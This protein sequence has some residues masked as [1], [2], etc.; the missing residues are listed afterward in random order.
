MAQTHDVSLAKKTVFAALV[1][2][3]LVA[4][5]EL[6]AYAGG[7][8]VAGRKFSLPR[9]QRQRDA[10][11]AS[12]GRVTLRANTRWTQDE[13]LHPYLGFAPPPGGITPVGVGSALAA[14]PPTRA[15][16][17]VIVAFVGGSFAQVFYDDGAPHL[18]ARLGELPMYRGKTLVPVS[19]GFA[20]YKQPQQLLSIVYL[21]AVGAEF[22][23]IVNI[24]GFNDLAIHPTENAA[25]GVFPPYPRRWHQRM[26]GVLPGGALRLMLRRVQLEQRRAALAEAFSTWPWRHLNAANFLYAVV[27]RDLD[28]RVTETD[29]ALL[30]EDEKGGASAVATGP[31]MSF[32]SDAEMVT[33][34]VD[35]WQRGSRLLDGVARLSGAR[36]YH[37]LQPNQYVPGS[38]PIGPTEAAVASNTQYRQIVAAGY[39]LLQRA[40][41][42]LTVEGVRFVDLSRVFARH[43][44]PLYVDSCCHVGARGN[45]IVAD[46]MFE[47]IRRDLEQ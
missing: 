28:R 17:R 29:N 24:D 41:E 16:N 11:V 23:L 5:I 2:L 30:G 37:F 9:L 40:G 39:P 43:S 42:A 10:L 22:D 3:V 14:A 18:L 7:V 26:E 1:L 45:T 4:A 36:Y 8:A 32:A 21:L 12:A 38:K 6:L 20:G 13:V 44:E 31:R 27:D 46:V 25:A 33:Y 19:L 34:L 47:T 35:L 15:G